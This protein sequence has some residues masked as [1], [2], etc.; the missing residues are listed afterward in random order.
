MTIDKAIEILTLDVKG[1]TKIDFDD[2][3]KALKL[4]IEAMKELKWFRSQLRVM[5]TTQLPGETKE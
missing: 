2:W 4:G 1:S 5:S 3:Q